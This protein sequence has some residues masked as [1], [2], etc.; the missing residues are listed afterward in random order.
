MLQCLLRDVWKDY[1]SEESLGLVD[2]WC[3]EYEKDKEE[4]EAKYKMT[5]G[6]ETHHIAKTNLWKN[7][8]QPKYDAIDGAMTYNHAS[9]F[10]QVMFDH[11]VFEVWSRALRCLRNF[12]AWFRKYRVEGMQ[13]ETKIEYHDAQR[14]TM[15]VCKIDVLI[16]NDDQLEIIDYKT[17]VSKMWS[18]RSIFHDLQLMFY[19]DVVRKEYGRMP[20]KIAVVDLYWGKYISVTPTQ[21]ELDKFGGLI[22]PHIS[23]TRRLHDT[24]AKGGT[25]DE[26]LPVLH[27]TFMCNRCEIAYE[28]G[29]P[30]FKKEDMH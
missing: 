1:F 30:Y 16:N 10:K 14:D 7:E 5:M 27:N 29:C 6:R 24:L 28:G 26:P 20:T 9:K 25:P 19:V 18:E 11:S 4:A 15:D 3:A 23:R 12:H 17:G 13:F 8:Y 22:G 2:K 21:D